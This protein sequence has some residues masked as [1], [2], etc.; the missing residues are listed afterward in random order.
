MNA[1]D[2]RKQTPLHVAVKEKNG[3]FI[4]LLLDNK[5]DSNVTDLEGNTPLDLAAKKL[6]ETTVN[7][8]PE[9]Y[10]LALKDEQVFNLLLTHS[11]ISKKD[12]AVKKTLKEAMASDKVKD[13]LVREKIVEIS[14][15]GY[16]Q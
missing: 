15:F 10:T 3:G 11:Y 1:R 9:G 6:Y 7:L 4:T 16:V 12:D 14:P 8:D 5:A 2:H 13:E